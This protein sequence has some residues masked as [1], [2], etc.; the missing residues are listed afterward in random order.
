MLTALIS[1]V[2]SAFGLV[3]D[4]VGLSRRHIPLGIYVP[5]LFVLLFAFTVILLPFGGYV[6][7]DVVFYPN[8][9]FYVLLMVV[10]AIAW[11]VLF[12]QSIQKDSVHEHELIVMTAPLLTILLAAMFFP[13]DFDLRVFILA[14]VAS[15]AL[16]LGKI[17]RK[18]FV[19][20]KQ[21]YNLFLGV[22]LMSL[23]SI[24]IRELLHYYS[25]IALYTVRTFFVAMFFWAYYRPHTQRVS[26]G[27][28]WFIGLSAALGVTTMLTRF[29]AFESLGIIYTTLISVMAPVIVFIAS[30]EIL[31]ERIKARIIIS[32]AVILVCVALAT[33]YAAS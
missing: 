23:E 29:Y 15:V 20:S 16:V 26:T 8:I 11:N 17:E 19:L 30:W 13:E 9:L 28:W 2:A 10:I 32:S 1:A 14:L 7:W 33:M 27:S 5:V 4:K 25:P 3:V 18:H 6:N 21:T 24:I 12:Y 22:I 31:H